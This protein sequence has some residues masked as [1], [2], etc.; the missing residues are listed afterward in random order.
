MSEAV[1]IDGWY[2]IQ[3]W[4]ESLSA[5]RGVAK[6]TLSAYTDDAKGYLTWLKSYDIR[7][8]AVVKDDVSR[9]LEAQ[10]AAGMSNATIARRKASIRSL[11]RFLRTEGVSAAD[12]TRLLS[13]GKRARSL[14]FV[15]SATQVA[16]LLDTAH[17]AARNSEESE[18]VLASL[19]RRAAMLEVLY[20]TGMR[21][22][23]AVRLEAAVLQRNEQGIAINGKGNKERIVILNDTAMDSMRLWRNRAAAYGVVSPVWLFHQV[24]DGSV[25]LGRSTVDRE[26]KDTAIAAG[27]P[28]SARVSAHILR[29]SFAT[30]L[31]QGGADLRVIQTLLGHADLGTTEIYTHV[32]TRHLEETMK[33]HPLAE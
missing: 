23:E 31:L 4:L 17:A 16:K 1:V 26:I 30:H 32:D 21:V 9:Y 18:F 27:I 14:P 12:P 13:G 20:A 29:H 28:N 8:E 2:R 25:P 19:A 5:E 15:L 10:S 3:A 7:L 24:R 22:S 11:H 6:N 33:A